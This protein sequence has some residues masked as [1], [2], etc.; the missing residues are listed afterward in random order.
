V[1]NQIEA[2]IARLNDLDARLRTVEGGQRVGLADVRSAWMTA[3]AT[4]TV[5]GTSDTTGPAAATWEDDQG[6][7]G[8]GWPQ[9]DVTSGRRVR[10][11]WWGRPIGLATAAAYRSLSCTIGVRLNGAVFSPLFPNANRQIANGNPL[12]VDV[13]VG[14]AATRI[15][16]PG[17]N[18]Y[19]LSVVFGNDQPAAPNLP[20]L[21]DVL[22]LVTPLSVT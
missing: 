20:T 12:P 8:T 5:F 22:L 14:G 16:P 2:L 4:Q 6:S 13:A 9:L 18:N 15:V 10:I 3:A 19:R 1:N 17:T 7:T 21:T 11:E